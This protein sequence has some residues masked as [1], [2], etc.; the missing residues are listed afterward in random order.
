M[1]SGAPEWQT[2]AVSH[3]TPIEKTFDDEKKLLSEHDITA[4]SLRKWLVSYQPL[5]G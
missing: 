4:L 1:N 5:I 2:I 3:V